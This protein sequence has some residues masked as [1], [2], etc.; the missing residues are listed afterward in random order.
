KAFAAPLPLN[1]RPIACSGRRGTECTEGIQAGEGNHA[2]TL[3]RPVRGA[4]AHVAGWPTL[5][6]MPGSYDLRRAITPLSQEAELSRG[7]R[8]I[9]ASRPPNPYAGAREPPAR[10]LRLHVVVRIAGT[11]EPGRAS[12]AAGLWPALSTVRSATGA[13]ATPS[14]PAFPLGSFDA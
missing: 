6:H 5:A 1:G 9:D 2:T 10:M 3:P 12:M 8:C 4:S 14:S 11:Y 7:I 13:S